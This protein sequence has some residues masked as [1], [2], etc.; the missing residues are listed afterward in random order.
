MSESHACPWPP[1]L[2]W[3]S[4]LADQ[5]WK[6]HYL[7]PLGHL[8]WCHQ[9]CHRGPYMSL[10]Y[11]CLVAASDRAAGSEWSKPW[12]AACAAQLAV[13]GWRTQ[14]IWLPPQHTPIH[15]QLVLVVGFSWQLVCPWSPVLWARNWRF[16]GA[17]W[18]LEGSDRPPELE[19]LSAFLF[20]HGQL[21]SLVGGQSLTA[22]S[23]LTHKGWGTHSVSL[24]GRK[25][26]FSSSSSYQPPLISSAPKA[27]LGKA[28]DWTQPW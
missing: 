5:P 28:Q 14:H 10:R 18:W 9:A 12:L 17:G 25:G 21:Q 26:F 7:W 20:A 1:R 19:S 3:G 23:V 8:K 4:C 16:T 13:A 15:S 6:W 2:K 22:D 24:G 11:V 27:K